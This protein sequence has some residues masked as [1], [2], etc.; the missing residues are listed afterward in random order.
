MACTPLPRS[1]QVDL[2]ASW[3][4]PAASTAPPREAGEVNVVIHPPGEH[5][6]SH[7]HG[8]SHL[9]AHAVHAH[10]HAHDDH[11][12][13]KRTR[14]LRTFSDAAKMAAVGVKLKSSAE[15][16]H[17]AYLHHECQDPLFCGEES[18]ESDYSES[19][20]GDQGGASVERV[21]W[22][23]ESTAMTVDV[24]LLMPSAIQT[25]VEDHPAS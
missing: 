5:G 1:N 4:V 21:A 12:V 9:H 8:H 20:G 23:R 14:I 6:H 25:M 2:Y 11:E 19:H 3:L 22:T 24:P 18:C 13:D 16:A 15:Q 17:E 7:H 10:D